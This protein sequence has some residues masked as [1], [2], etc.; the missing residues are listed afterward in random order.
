MSELQIK[1]SACCTHSIMIRKNVCRIAKNS[2]ISKIKGA[3]RFCLQFSIVLP[4]PATGKLRG[5]TGFS[6][7]ELILM[8]KGKARLHLD[9]TFRVAIHLCK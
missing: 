6:N 4:D 3:K 2:S 1:S 7:P 9:S 5:I 8:I